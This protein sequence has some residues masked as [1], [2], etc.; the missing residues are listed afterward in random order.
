MAVTT[1]SNKNKFNLRNLPD[2][3]TAA[4][5]AIGGL[6]KGKPKEAPPAK[7]PPKFSY[8]PTVGEQATPQKSNYVEPYVP[9]IQF[10]PDKTVDYTVKDKSYH[11]TPEEYKRLDIGGKHGPIT[12]NVQALIDYE[13]AV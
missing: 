8:Q 1:Q 3:G 2:L 11:L 7:T 9:K 10:N 13:A 4:G 6:I 12:P 5:T